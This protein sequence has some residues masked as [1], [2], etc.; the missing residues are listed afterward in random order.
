MRQPKVLVTRNLSPWLSI[1]LSVD[2]LQKIKSKE[3]S[4]NHKGPTHHRWGS[5]AIC[6]RSKRTW[7][8]RTSQQRKQLQ[9]FWWAA[10]DDGA[11]ERRGGICS[12]K[13]STWRWVCVFTKFSVSIL[14][15]ITC[16]RCGLVMYF[17]ERIHQPLQRSLLPHLHPHLPGQQRGLVWWCGL[18]YHFYSNDNTKC[19]SWH[20]HVSSILFI[21][22]CFYEP[23]T[24]C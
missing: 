5:L 1:R 16:A 11:S 7:H 24:F 19:V 22:H 21:F 15:S 8:E 23:R 18:V 13:R 4:I 2:I 17:T 9:R 10:E 20:L 6:Q 14:P 3:H 12:Q